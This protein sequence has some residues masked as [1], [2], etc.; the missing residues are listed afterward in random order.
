MPLPDGPGQVNQ[1]VW[2]VDF[3]KNFLWIL[4]NLLWKMLN[5]VYQASKKKIDMSS[6][7]G[8]TPVRWICDKNKN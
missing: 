4:Y 5:F 1:S 3:G 6:T 2:L 8:F 7:A